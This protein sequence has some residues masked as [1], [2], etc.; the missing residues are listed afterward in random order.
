M[1][2]T[3]PFPGFTYTW[4]GEL[5]SGSFPACL[6]P[7]DGVTGCGGFGDTGCDTVDACGCSVP[8]TLNVS[9]SAPGSGL[10]GKTGTITYD[11]GNDW[12]TGDLSGCTDGGNRANIIVYCALGTW[13][14]SFQGG[15]GSSVIPPTSAT[16]DPFEL[17][18]DGTQ[19]SGSCPCASIGDAFTVTV[20]A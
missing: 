11:A 17:V 7:C 1:A 18:F 13:N 10:D 8:K 9:V 2:R 4:N 15:C 6:L 20:T 19:S 16:C 5:T 3:D 12:W 14:F